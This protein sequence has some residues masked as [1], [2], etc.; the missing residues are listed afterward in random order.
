MLMDKITDIAAAIKARDN[1]LLVGHAIPD[2]DCIGSLLAMRQILKEMGKSSRMVL[3]DPVPHIYHYLAGSDE[4]LLP[5][6]LNEP[7]GDVIFLDCAD[8]ERVGDE[9]LQCLR[10]RGFTISMDHH[11]SNTM[12]GDMN[13]VQ[14]QM[15][16]TAELVYLLAATLPVAIN[17]LMAN[18][19]FA[20][21]VQDTGSFHHS[22]TRA[23]TFRIAADLL[24]HGVDMDQTRINLFESKSR[25][26]TSLLTCA[27]NSLQFSEEGRM[28]WMTV[29][30]KDAERLGF[31]DL[32]P[33]GI[34]N[35]ALIIE[36]VEV[37]MLFREIKPGL[38]KAGFRSKGNV[39]VARLA[40]SFGG[41]GHRQASGVTLEGTLDEVR[42][43]VLKAVREVTI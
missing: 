25:A 41:G 33:E 36:G 11:Q 8:E 16:A 12:F 31:M 13:Y 34:I 7:I 28:A 9:L 19:L 26:E 22:N 20:G 37:G 29:T 21:I 6:Q 30:Y 39:D 43:R 38:I 15:A 42:G 5:A 18:A 32:H 40:S 23:E 35:H 24:D 10:E 4:V 3:Q 17:P 14:P 2:G 27:L 1:F